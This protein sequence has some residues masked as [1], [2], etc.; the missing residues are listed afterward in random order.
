ASGY[1][2]RRARARLPSLPAR[3][4][5]RIQSGLGSWHAVRPAVGRA[6][7]IDPDVVAAD[8]Q[9][10]LRLATRRGHAGSAPL[11]HVAAARLGLEPDYLSLPR[12]TRTP[13][14][15]CT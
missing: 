2:V 1:A 7:R 15:F 12:T 11:R 4:L 5:C 14:V 9:M 10:A 3:A 8:R 6:H 13:S